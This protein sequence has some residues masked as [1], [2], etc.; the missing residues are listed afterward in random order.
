M[1]YRTAVL[2][3]GNIARFHLEAMKSLP[4]IRACAI[5]DVQKRRADRLAAEY[6]LSS[7]TDYKDMI[8]REKPDLVVVTL[9]HYLHA[10]AAKFAA[11][12]GIHILLE[13]PM[14]LN[15]R[16]CDGII[17]AAKAG[18]VRVMVGHT[19]HYMAENL[20]AKA[21]IDS[22]RL[23]RLVM[24]G[25]TRHQQYDLP[26]RPD[27]F[28]EHSKAGGGIL[29]NLGS[30][31]IDKIQWLTGGR[32]TRVKAVVDY[33]PTRGDVESGGCALLETSAGVPATLGVSGHPGG[34]VDE[35]ELRFTGGSLKL[36]TG[37]GLWIGEGK[38]YRKLP[39]PPQPDPFVRQLEDLLGAIREDRE[40]ECSMAYS[41]SVVA[42]VQSLYLS[43]ERGAEI[44]VEQAAGSEDARHA[45]R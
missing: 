36:R 35:T 8:V 43:S 18:G 29:T 16:E 31:C 6:G 27:W 17:A 28:F 10:E 5:A 37:S 2:G 32:I 7:Y 39:V 1:L 38:E 44:E 25:D 30:H 15:V 12:R 3:A 42:A 33:T 20:E 13:K 26:G 4:D 14:A 22:G 40:P 21:W 11:E 24:I 23:G 41:R 34:V 9:P 19:Q 45:R